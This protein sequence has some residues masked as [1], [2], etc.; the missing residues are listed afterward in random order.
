MSGK[1]GGTES[2]QFAPVSLAKTMR[3]VERQYLPT[4]IVRL[5]CSAQWNI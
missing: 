3:L 2:Y 4:L 5:N 1:P